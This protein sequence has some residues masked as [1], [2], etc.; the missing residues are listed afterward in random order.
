MNQP[1]VESVVAALEAR[2]FAVFRGGK[3]PLNLNLVILRS[4]P[5]TVDAFDDLLVVFWLEGTAWKVRAFRITADPGK[6]SL[7]QPKR[8]DGTAMMAPGQV[9]GALKFGTHHPG[10]DGAYECLV[11]AVP[12]PVLRFLSVADFTAGKG[13]PSTSSTTQI[14]HAN[15]AHPST[16]VGAWSEGCAVFADPEEFASF[17]EL[18]HDSEDAGNGATFTLSILEWPDQAAA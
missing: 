10:T 4:I 1:S 6:P 9:R 7:E 13:T 2:K 15:G 17:M 18:C 3:H 12:I 16:I 8:S 5:G 11:P 14:H